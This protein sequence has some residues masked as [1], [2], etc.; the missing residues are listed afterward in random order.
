ML[1][2]IF[3]FI[4]IFIADSIDNTKF[5]WSRKIGKVRALLAVYL[6][7]AGILIIGGLTETLLTTY[8]TFGVF[9]VIVWI[10]TEIT[11]KIVANNDIQKEKNEYVKKVPK[12]I[13]IGKIKKEIEN[14]NLFYIGHNIDLNKP[15]F[16][17]IKQMELH[18]MAIGATG[19]G[20]T[21]C[22]FLPSIKDALEKGL[23][24]IIIDG[25]ADR[26]NIKTIYKMVKDSGREKDFQLLSIADPN[27]SWTW[28]PLQ[29]GNST[30][31]A[32][33][34]I[35]SM[36]WSKSNLTDSSYYREICHNALQLL[37]NEHE[38]LESEPQTLLMTYKLLQNP[39][40]AKYPEF[41]KL[42]KKHS[43]DITSIITELS[44]IIHSSFGCLF[45]SPI[46]EI[47]LFEGYKN[48]KIIYFALD[49][50]SYEIA[51]KRLGRMITQDLNTLSGKIQSSID[52]K[53]RKPIGIFI[54][55]F[56]SFGT[57]SFTNVLAKGRASRFML[58]L[59]LTSIQDL[60]KIGGPA[61]R[62]Q[63][64]QNTNTKIGM[65][66]NELESAKALSD[67]LGVHKTKETTRQTISNGFFSRLHTITEKIV[68]KKIIPPQIFLE[69]G[70]N[71]AVYIYGK[72]SGK[73]ILSPI[74]IDEN[75]A[76]YP[77]IKIR[78]DKKIQPAPKKPEPKSV[79]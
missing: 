34:L 75:T 47:D 14:K 67:S 38:K 60:D 43:K 78:K 73:L 74:I 59:L 61:Y 1:R 12:N 56:Q 9:A 50:Q 19:S 58:L 44:I 4:K 32:D 63:V 70:I 53:D 18:T 72:D 16:L 76:P 66:M 36:D 26:L 35:G 69:L 55:E 79:F 17:T 48:N 41:A 27:R 62:A 57:E 11:K 46:G 3:G 13:H 68:D 21:S 28:N 29:M 39:D 64:M 37:F 20:K 77:E 33:K 22:I 25:K 5:L 49:T 24:V 45:E 65:K 51:S 42:I 71:E 7:G 54:D 8:I 2:I 15:I 6:I 23:P 30:Q 31:I 52:Y 40:I 10:S